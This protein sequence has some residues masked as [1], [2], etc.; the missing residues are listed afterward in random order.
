MH[1]NL[2]L[3]ETHA[4]QAYSDRCIQI[5]SMNYEQSLIVS[6]KEIITNLGINCIEELDD[7]YINQLIQLE[8]KVIVIG[9]TQQ[10]RLPPLSIV[11]AMAEK[12]IGIEFMSI[13][14]ACR[15]YN[16]LLNEHRQVVACFIL[17]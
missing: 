2:E 15:T 12:K 11:K 6:R 13:G 9:H 14:A 16:V 8:P 10:G 4:I 7:N 5:N 17:R 1:I 3:A